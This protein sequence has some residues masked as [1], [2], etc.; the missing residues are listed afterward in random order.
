MI[1]GWLWFGLCVLVVG[2]ICAVIAETF[3]KQGKR[4]KKLEERLDRLEN[5]KSKSQH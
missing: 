1:T 4:I 2:G 3:D 5:S